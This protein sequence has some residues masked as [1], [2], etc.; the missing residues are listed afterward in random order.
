MAEVYKITNKTNGKYYI[1]QA[2]K[3][4][5]QSKTKWG[6][7]GRWKSHIREALSSQKDH[8]ILLNNAI[9][10]YGHS[11][12][13]LEVI[14]DCD[15]DDIDNNE[16]LYIK[17]YNS[18]VPNG[19]NLKTG[20]AKGKD[21][22]ETKL[23]K[24]QMRIGKKH[25]DNVKEN[26][27]KGQL[28]NRRNKKPRKYPEDNDLPKYI[29]A[30]RG[31]NGIISYS[32]CRFP[33]GVNKKKYISKNFRISK[34][35]SKEAALQIAKEYLEQLKIKYAYVEE[36][37]PIKNKTVSIETKVSNLINNE[38]LK[39]PEHITPI[40]DGLHKI[41]YLVEEIID[42]DGNKYPIKQIT[43][44]TNRWNLDQ[45]KKYLECV[46]NTKDSIDP[47]IELGRRRRDGTNNSLPKYINKYK[48]QGTYTGYK[49]NGYPINGKKYSKC[50][51]SN[52]LTMEEKF[53]LAC[54]HLKELKEKY[55]IVRKV[56]N[57]KSTS[58]NIE[59]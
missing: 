39:L 35:G 42:N 55:P 56:K 46:V 28:G 37:R 41:G 5:S 15:L 40:Y 12:F 34:Y 18:L 20:G 10:K 50:F 6:A 7:I 8:C 53:K 9:R 49:V 22:E 24:K 45:A 59:I 57:A 1:G 17:Q 48:Y 38:K 32:M 14:C 16:M 2:V 23:K 33:I 3:Y 36:Q 25:S 44:C 58:K 21:S 31:S 52:K 26:I 54:D 29:N 30:I 19:Y 11:N 4:L 43:K 51:S 13:D 27:G 47:D